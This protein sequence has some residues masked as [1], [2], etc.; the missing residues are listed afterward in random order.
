MRQ[1]SSLVRGVPYSGAS[2]RAGGP[3]AEARAALEMGV[4]ETAFPVEV[5][6]GE[7]PTSFMIG[8]FANLS[9]LPP[10]ELFRF[11]FFFL[12]LASCAPA[13]TASE[14]A[15]VGLLPGALIPAGVPGL[16]PNE[17]SRTEESSP[18]LRCVFSAA[19]GQESNGGA[20]G[21]SASTGITIAGD[22]APAGAAPSALAPFFFLKCCGSTTARGWWN[23]L[24]SGPLA[25]RVT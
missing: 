19:P 23:Q 9:P 7:A 20:E 15:E 6:A 21:A 10:T 22:S 5:L 3:S 14:G 1:G 12:S 25:G 24:V 16:T 17:R 18:P 11:F 8:S 4:A 13:P 2:S